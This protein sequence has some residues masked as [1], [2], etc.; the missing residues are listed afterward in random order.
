MEERLGKEGYH[1][2]KRGRGKK[3]SKI[4]GRERVWQDRERGRRKKDCMIG[5]DAGKRRIAR[6]D[7]RKRKRNRKIG[8]E[9]E[10]GSMG[11]EEGT[12]RGS[13]RRMIR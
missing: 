9:N 1:G 10:N 13:G 3:D 11:K 6:Y 7:E 12:T 5:K 4:G 2:R 8:R